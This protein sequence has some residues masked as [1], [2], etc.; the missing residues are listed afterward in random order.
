MKKILYFLSSIIL[1]GTALCGCSEDN[2]E[3]S[4]QMPP[5]LISIIPKAASTGETAV[6][7]GVYFSE[8][9]ADNEVTINGQSAEI[10][11]AS[12]N[13]LVIT[14]PDNPDGSYPVKLSVRGKQVEGLKITY[15]PGRVKELSVLQCMPS[16]AFVG[17]EIKVIGQ[18]FSP[19]ASE[20]KV[21]INGVE[22]V[23]K[24]ATEK[25]LT[26]VIPDTDE[27][28]YPVSVTVDGK[29]ATGSAFTYGHIVKLTAS[30][31]EP[32][33]GSAGDEVV[34]TGEAFGETPADCHVTVN[35]KDAEV[36][37]VTPSSVTIVMPENPAGTYPVVITVDGKTVDNLSFTYNK[38]TLYV[39]TIA[40]NGTA[41]ILEGVG[42][43][44]ATKSPQGIAFAPDGNLYIAMQ[45]NKIVMRMT[46]D[47]NVTQFTLNIPSGT[48]ALDAPWGCV[49]DNAGNFYLAGKA[50]K[51][52]YKIAPDGSATALNTYTWKGPM[53]MYIDKD[54]NLYVAD[55]DD[56][57]IVKMTTAGVVLA[58]YDMSDCSQGP[59]AVT[60]DAK[61]NVYAANGANYKMFMFTPD[62]TRSVL[63]G[64][65][66]KPTAA[67]WSDGLP[68]DLSTATMGQSFC[69]NIAQDGTMYISDLLAFVVRTLVPDANGD[70]TKGTL[71]TIAGIPFASGNVDGVSTAAKFK[72]L[73]GVVEHDGKIYVAD[74]GNHLIRCISSK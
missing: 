47:F 54:Q 34:I 17:E 48:P 53:D 16:Y 8:N 71:T 15:A 51:M 74:S 66:T 57:K 27:G 40:G 39:T 67:T 55:R 5:K 28:T 31:I 3:V 70:Y 56:K 11:S 33:N 9:P 42:T 50:S 59:C 73:G 23:V 44:A 6:I 41:A 12:S 7:S 65:G 32:D 49:F 38:K 61:G 24:E 46:P 37:E 30:T 22:A 62:G 4:V 2:E 25:M 68:G 72:A 45:N 21:T 1:C 52:V 64:N 60:V 35:G 10:T 18:C 69:I 43:A 36:K 14:L 63:F 19:V 20:N 29:T 13:R 26:I 58:T